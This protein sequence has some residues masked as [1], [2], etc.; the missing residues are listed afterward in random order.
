[1]RWPRRG[2]FTRGKVLPVAAFTIGAAFLFYSATLNDTVASASSIETPSVVSAPAATFAGT[3]VGS[4]P[5]GTSPCWSPGVT[6]PRD[7]TFNATGLS[8]APTAV[9]ISMTFGGPNHSFVGD[10]VAVLIAPNGASHTVF[11]RTLATTA[12]A[13]GGSSDLAGPYVFS[14]VAPAPPSGGWWQQAGTTPATMAAG[15]YRTTASGGAG[16]VSYTHLT[17]PTILRV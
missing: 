13:F 14:D 1:M 10:V 3:G 8:G 6:T 11:G 7:V 16:A 4:I 2:V 17:L 9:D 15:T 12:T 5:D